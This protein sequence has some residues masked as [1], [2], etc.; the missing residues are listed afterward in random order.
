VYSEQKKSAWVIRTGSLLP[1][2][3][4]CQSGYLFG[5]TNILL[6]LLAWQFHNSSIRNLSK[7]R[8]SS[9]AL[10]YAYDDNTASDYLRPTLAMGACVGTITLRRVADSGA[11]SNFQ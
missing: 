5:S 9:S 3:M 11:R 2:G 1:E 4:P 8:T 6:L 7:F 10:P